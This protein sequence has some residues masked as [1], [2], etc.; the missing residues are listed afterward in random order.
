MFIVNSTNLFSQL[1][2]TVCYGFKNKPDTN[3][4]KLKIIPTSCGKSFFNAYRHDKATFNK[5]FKGYKGLVPSDYVLY[6]YIYDCK[7]HI[8]I[9]DNAICEEIY[10][11][12]KTKRQ[13][14]KKFFITDFLKTIKFKE[15]ELTVECFVLDKT[16]PKEYFIDDIYYIT[17]IRRITRYVYR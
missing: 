4:V 11:N 16:F 17:Y 3:L 8:P 2:T 10:I 12:L 7:A 13:T 9:Q 1:G 15:E 14:V 6:F 5:L